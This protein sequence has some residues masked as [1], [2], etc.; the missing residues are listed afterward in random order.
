MAHKLSETQTGL[1]APEKFRQYYLREHLNSGGLA[2]IWLATDARGKSYALR[3]L[4]AEHRFNFGAR[5]RFAHGNKVMS[6][7]MKSDY[8]VSYVEHGHDYLLMDYLEADNLK[9]VYSR[10]DDVLMENVAQIL[11]DAAVGLG[12]VHESGYMHLDF[13]PENVLVTR[14]AAVRVI[15]FDTAQPLPKKPVRL[16]KNP[17]TPGYMAPEQLKGDPVDGRSDIFAYGVM[18][19]ELLTNHKPFGSGTPAEILAEIMKSGGPTPLSEYN[20][21]IPP[22]LERIV[23]QC[24]SANP[25]RRYPD[26]CLLIAD[27]QS[28]LYV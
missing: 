13:K 27:L 10:R 18:A 16:A 14:N 5:L 6:R 3:K 2:D 22:M 15:D 21:G 11:I 24:L 8:I 4:K 12:H 26:T 9:Q 17:G 28:V 1:K 19:Y 20:P 7:L 23:L 25:D